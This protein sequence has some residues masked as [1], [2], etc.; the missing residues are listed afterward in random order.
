MCLLSH[1]IMTEHG[2]LHCL[3]AKAFFGVL[4]LPKSFSGRKCSEKVFERDIVAW[5]RGC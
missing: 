1:I 2:W 5:N 4:Y 3:L